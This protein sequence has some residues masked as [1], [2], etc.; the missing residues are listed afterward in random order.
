[1]SV[2]TRADPAIRD[3]S[4]VKLSPSRHVQ[5]T[6]LLPTFG[7]PG[8]LIAPVAALPH[9]RATLAV[10]SPSH[11]G[12]QACPARQPSGLVALERLAGAH[13]RASVVHPEAN[14]RTIYDA[15]TLPARELITDRLIMVQVGF[16]AGSDLPGSSSLA[17]LR[18]L[19]PSTKVRILP[20]ELAVLHEVRDLT[21][22]R[23]L[24]PTPTLRSAGTG[25]RF[26]ER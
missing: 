1:M 12:S 24:L 2:P 13:S 19:A 26:G 25:H 11:P 20:R 18:T 17:G 23:P 8:W 10:A 7:Q 14:R 6:G 16:G 21:P 5:D 22:Q 15:T 9:D 4:A 3:N